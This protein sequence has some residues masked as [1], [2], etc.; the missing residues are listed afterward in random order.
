MQRTE[1]KM[2]QKRIKKLI[3]TLT[4]LKYRVAFFAR[5]NAVI[6]TLLTLS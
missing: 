1:V 3:E 6:V 4:D 5:H 2:L